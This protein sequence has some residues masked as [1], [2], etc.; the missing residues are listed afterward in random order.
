M[1]ETLGHF[2]NSR[3]QSVIL[4]SRIAWHVDEERAIR[5]RK[6]ADDILPLLNRLGS[7]HDSRFLALPFRRNL[8]ARFIHQIT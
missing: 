6:N 4:I 5:I 2:K 7:V 1:K 8:S 3:S